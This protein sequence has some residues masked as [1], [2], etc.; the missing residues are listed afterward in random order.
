[1]PL[2]W[3]RVGKVYLQ[4]LHPFSIKRWISVDCSMRAHLQTIFA[5]EFAV[6]AIRT[7][8]VTMLPIFRDLVAE[9]MAG[10][11]NLNVVEVLDTRDGLED[12]LRAIQP[13]LVLIGLGRNERDDIG[14][15]LVRLLPNAKV[16][17]FSR[18]GRHAFVHRMH[19]QRTALLDL[20]AQVLIDVIVGF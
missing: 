16:I 1:V 5:Q 11:R 18:D 17:A 3:I 8:S 15:P 6:A 7:V 12:R 2:A 14:L 19:P 9:L 10:H 4:L 20:S 13:D